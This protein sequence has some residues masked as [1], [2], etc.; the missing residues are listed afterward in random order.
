MSVTLNQVLPWGRSVDE[1]R[2]LFDLSEQDLQTAILG[3]GD[4]PASFNAELTAMGRSVV[5]IDPI[6]AFSKEEI[7]L[8]VAQTREAII[9]QVKQSST[10]TSGSILKALTNSAGIASSACAN[11]WT[12]IRPASPRAVTLHR[13]CP[14]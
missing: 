3:C 10:T 11:S 6:Y 14:R 5:S 2:R 4:G 13:L 7:E 9:S 12:T 1:Y 8:R